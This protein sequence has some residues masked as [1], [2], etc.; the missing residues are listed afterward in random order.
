MLH[1]SALQDISLT[2][3]FESSEGDRLSQEPFL[4]KHGHPY[5]ERR[6]E[7]YAAERSRR[8]FYSFIFS[9]SFNVVLLLITA[10]LLYAP[11]ANRQANTDPSI[12]LPRRFQS[13]ETSR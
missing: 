8:P 5:N 9:L 10:A 1:L 2:M 7:I 13:P 3:A 12:L 4:E 6:E 11:H